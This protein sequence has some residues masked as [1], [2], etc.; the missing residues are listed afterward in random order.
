M[1]LL[2]ILEENS[3]ETITSEFSCDVVPNKRLKDFFCWGT[4]FN[5]S[6]KVLF[7]IEIKSLKD[8]MSTAVTRFLRILISNDI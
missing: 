5:L 7:E 6:G 8:K 3:N 1:E 2:E 4:V